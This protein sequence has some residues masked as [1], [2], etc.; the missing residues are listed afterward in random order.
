MSGREQNV[1]RYRFSSWRYRWA[2]CAVRLR[3]RAPTRSNGSRLRAP[4]Q[5]TVYLID[6]GFKR[7]V[8]FRPRHRGDSTE[9]RLG[10]LDDRFPLA[11]AAGI[12]PARTCRIRVVWPLPRHRA[13]IDLLHPEMA[14]SSV[15][16][17]L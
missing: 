10:D 15:A 17:R 3:V 6:E 16:T 7:A 1:I 4:G 5:A 8:S 12:D 9:Q 13:G 11:S 14:G 2:S